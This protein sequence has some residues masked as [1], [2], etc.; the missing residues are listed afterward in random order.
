MKNDFII[1]G[2][3]TVILLPYK[4]GQLECLIDTADLPIMQTIRGTWFAFRHNRL[5]TYYAFTQT[6]GITKYAHRLITGCPARLR[7]MHLNGP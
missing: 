2:R 3:T 5:R 7:V 1:N 4:G 6:N